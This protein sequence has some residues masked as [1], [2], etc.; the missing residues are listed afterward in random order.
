M[1]LTFKHPVLLLPCCFGAVTPGLNQ[2]VRASLMRDPRDVPHFQCLIWL[3]ASS[4]MTST[5]PSQ[6]P[7]TLS[8]SACTRCVH[9]NN[10]CFADSVQTTSFVDILMSRPVALQLRPPKNFRRHSEG[11]GHGPLVAGQSPTAATAAASPQYRQ[12]QQQGSLTADPA[13]WTNFGDQVRRSTSS[14]LR[15]ALGAGTRFSILSPS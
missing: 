5:A 9:S 2:G 12:Q 1:S 3:A 10:R 7:T 14:Q 4:Q 11:H 15:P 13:L 8:S 6:R